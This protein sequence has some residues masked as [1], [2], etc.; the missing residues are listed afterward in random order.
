MTVPEEGLA[1]EHEIPDP[2]TWRGKTEIWGLVE[3]IS[4]V[5]EVLGALNGK[6]ARDGMSDLYHDCR[7]FLNSVADAAR[8]EL[9]EGIYAVCGIVLPLPQEEEDIS[10]PRKAREDIR[11]TDDNARDGDHLR[12]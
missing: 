1:P 12:G 4:T 3:D 11:G 6:V 5:E 10:V 9:A 8:E 7:Q 2:R